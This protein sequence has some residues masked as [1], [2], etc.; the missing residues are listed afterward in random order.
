MYKMWGVLVLRACTWLM[1]ASSEIIDA[2]AAVLVDGRM[3]QSL[4][5]ALRD[6]FHAI[7]K[8]SAR[9]LLILSKRELFQ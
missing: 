2:Q 1:R 5:V 3:E 6:E 7:K 4:F 9:F 8:D